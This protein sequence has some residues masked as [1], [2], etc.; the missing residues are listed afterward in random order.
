MHCHSLASLAPFIRSLDSLTPGIT[1]G[2][3]PP[4][5]SAIHT[6]TQSSANPPPSTTPSPSSP[7]HREDGT[8]SLSSAS[9]K[10]LSA[11]SPEALAEELHSILKTLPLEHASC[12]EDIYGMDVGIMWG[13]DDL[14]W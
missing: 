9:A 5:P 8:P 2:S 11:A 3:A 13:S 12:S 7:R 14:E 4:T 1:G 10:S 6:L